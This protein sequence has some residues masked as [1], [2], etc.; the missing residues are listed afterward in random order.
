M[1]TKLDYYKQLT[2]GGSFEVV[3]SAEQAAVVLKAY[4]YGVGLLSSDETVVLDAVIGQLKD[5][6]WP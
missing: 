3:L 2:Q 1:A 6:I 4:D 5:Q